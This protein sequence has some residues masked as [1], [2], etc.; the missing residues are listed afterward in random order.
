MIRLNGD[1]MRKRLSSVL[2]NEQSCTD[3][4]E[5]RKDNQG[6]RGYGNGSHTGFNS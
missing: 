4:F 6:K 2:G 5:R 3:R 1:N